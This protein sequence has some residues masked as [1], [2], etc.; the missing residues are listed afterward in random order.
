MTL[1]IEANRADATGYEPIYHGKDLVG[2][3]TCGGYGLCVAKSLAMGY[4]NAS[5]SN[6]SEELT[7]TLLGEPRPARL[8]PQAL[9]DP[10]GLRMRS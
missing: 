1:E 2:F 7:V 6:S 8:V 10:K 9:V 3:V 5:M 4:I